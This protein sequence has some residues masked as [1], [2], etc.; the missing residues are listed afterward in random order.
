[1]NLVLVDEVGVQRNTQHK[2]QHD[3]INHNDEGFVVPPPD[4]IVD[5]LAMMIKVLG[6]SVALLAM[7]ARGLHIG[8][9]IIT[10]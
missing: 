8:L 6:A 1:M 2:L 10:K 3:G 5:P 7:L 4:A 9:T